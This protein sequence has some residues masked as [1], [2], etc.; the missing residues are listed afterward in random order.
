MNNGKKTTITLKEFNRGLSPDD[1]KLIEAEKKYYQVIVALREKRK[2][3]GLTQE[4]LARLS[5]VPRTTI[6]KVES[7]SRNATLQTLMALAQAMGK[8]VELRLV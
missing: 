2:K 6:T 4:G 8:R 3:M 7:G 5:N 1:R